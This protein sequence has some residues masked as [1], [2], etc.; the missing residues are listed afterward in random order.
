[1]VLYRHVKRDPRIKRCAQLTLCTKRDLEHQCN[2]RQEPRTEGLREN[3]PVDV[4]QSGATF[5]QTLVVRQSKWGRRFCGS[6]RRI[7][8]R[9]VLVLQVGSTLPELNGIYASGE[10]RKEDDE[11]HR[12]RGEGIVSDL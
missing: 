4:P 11:Q 8:F 2:P 10:R 6:M 5:Y 7:P 12:C 1:M 3:P 9:R